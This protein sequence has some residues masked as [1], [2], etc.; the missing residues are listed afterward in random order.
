MTA[1]VF[2]VDHVLEGSKV[3]HYAETDRGNSYIYLSPAM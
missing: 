3:G 1:P 2:L